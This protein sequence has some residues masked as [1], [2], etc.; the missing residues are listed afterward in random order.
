MVIQPRPILDQRT[1]P[2]KEGRCPAPGMTL[3][4]S[5]LRPAVLRSKRSACVGL[6]LAGGSSTHPGRRVVTLFP[7]QRTP[8]RAAMLDPQ[9]A[10]QA[11]LP[12]RGNHRR[13][14]IVLLAAVSGCSPRAA[15]L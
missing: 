13:R 12:T 8:A 6:S 7:N 2:G 1:A 15:G 4:I 9:R 14:G 5:P 11:A 10:D 3:T